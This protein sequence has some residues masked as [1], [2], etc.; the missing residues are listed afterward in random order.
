MCLNYV[1][2]CICV[3]EVNYYETG[4]SQSIVEKFGEKKRSEKVGWWKEHNWG[5][6]SETMEKQKWEKTCI[7]D[8]DMWDRICCKVE[9]TVLVVSNEIWHEVL[10]ETQ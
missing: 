8:S 2:V 3:W 1:I 4:F 5:I 6:E 10:A 7:S 9:L